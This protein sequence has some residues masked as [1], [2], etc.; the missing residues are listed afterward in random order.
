MALSRTVA[1]AIARAF[2]VDVR[3]QSNARWYTRAPHSFGLAFNSHCNQQLTG[4]IFR[5]RIGLGSLGNMAIRSL[6]R[7][8]I[9]RFK[10]HAEADDHGYMAGSAE[11]RLSAVW[12]ITRDV[13]A[14]F[15]EA[16]AERRLQ[17]DVAVLTRGKG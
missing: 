13:W 6:N 4:Y 16:D 12:E 8:Q 9:A 1:F 10:S 2:L 5:C 14:F 15:R 11:E 17:R 7:T 3:K